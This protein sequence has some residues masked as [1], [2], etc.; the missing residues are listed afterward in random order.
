MKFTSYVILHVF[1]DMLKF[2]KYFKWSTINRR[3]VMILL[4]MDKLPLDYYQCY[5]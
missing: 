3:N 4:E 1:K 2:S 5:D